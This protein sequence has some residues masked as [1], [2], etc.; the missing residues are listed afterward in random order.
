M[1]SAIL[2]AVVTGGA[3]GIGLAYVDI[4]LERKYSV[5]IF[6]ICCLQPVIASL[7]IKYPD[8]IIR[9]YS[10]DVGSDESFRNAY[11]SALGDMRIDYFDVF[12]NNAG[13]I[14]NMFLDIDRQIQ[15]N[16]MGAIRGTELAIKSSTQSLTKMASKPVLIVCTASTN[17][18]IPADADM[19]PVYVAS[20]FAIVGFVRS[21]KPI[22]LRY[23]VRVNAICP[24][25]VNTPMVQ[26]GI[27]SE[28]MQYLDTDN[29]GG[30]L[31]PRAC[32]R[33]LLTLIDNTDIAGEIITV[34]PSSGESGKVELL[35][36]LG[37]F[38]YLGA[39]REDNGAGKID[40]QTKEL[41][42]SSFNAIKAGTMPAFDA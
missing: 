20:K 35:D 16:L 40:I 22:A 39:W 3:M 21:L 26:S 1:E 12:I 23:N 27:T 10:C 14:R 18:L 5:C 33:A 41:V 19:A 2:T 6:D 25:T 11:N 38:D 42:D 32:A 30:I 34:H 8:A 37:Q 31:E 24:V 4:L 17:G 29:R 9:G 28:I 36:P 13:I 7:L 15:V